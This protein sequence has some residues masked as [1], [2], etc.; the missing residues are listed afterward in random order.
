ML[1]A[2]LYAHSTRGVSLPICFYFI[3]TLAHAVKN[4][5]ITDLGLAITLWIVGDEELIG[6]PVLGSEARHLLA[7][8][9]SLIFGDD[10]IRKP[11]VAH[12]ILPK[13]LDNLLPYD[14]GEHHSFHILS[15][16]VHDH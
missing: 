8:K 7:R 6:D 1:L 12:E 2:V 5:V 4:R 14:I 16:V 3:E 15:E 11:E 13:K 10:G 9:V